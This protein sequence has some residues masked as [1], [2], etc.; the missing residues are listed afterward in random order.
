MNLYSYHLDL[1][2]HTL[3]FFFYIKFG[4]NSFHLFSYA[5]IKE[6]IREDE[7]GENLEPFTEKSLLALNEESST[8]DEAG[9]S[10]SSNISS[11]HTQQQQQQTFVYQRPYR[12]NQQQQQQQ[13]QRLPLNPSSSTGSQP[14][15]TNPGETVDPLSQHQQIP[16]TKRQFQ[17]QKL[18]EERDKLQQKQQQ[19]LHYQMDSSPGSPGS[20]QSS[21]SVPLAQ[22]LASSGEPPP[23]SR[24]A[25][26]GM[27]R[28]SYSSFDSKFWGKFSSL[29]SRFLSFSL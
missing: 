5:K 8:K 18:E 10:T 19:S 13:Q 27:S 22:P 25:K 17:L 29:M 2:P 11:R 1:F 28:F 23:W 3:V 9:P 7:K 24:R 12:N 20:Q 4:T 26:S 14:Q 15:Q 21:Y 16:L 6:N